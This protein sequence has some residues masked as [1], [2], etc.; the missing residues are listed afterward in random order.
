MKKLQI[1]TKTILRTA[2][3]I[4]IILLAVIRTF[5]P[6]SVNPQQFEQADRAFAEHFED[7]KEDLISALENETFSMEYWRAIDRLGIAITYGMYLQPESDMDLQWCTIVPML[8][9]LDNPDIYDALSES[10]RTLISGF[11]Q[12]HH[13]SNPEPITEQDT[14]AIFSA[15]NAAKYIVAA[16]YMKS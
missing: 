4:V 8:D 3:T 15:I 9:E 5:A 12:N 6:E 16:P 1:S 13:Y 11:L 2:A 7:A 14:E 10:D